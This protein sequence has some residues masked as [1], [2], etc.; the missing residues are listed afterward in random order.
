MKNIYDYLRLIKQWVGIF[1]M[2]TAKFLARAMQCV[3][4]EGDDEAYKLFTWRKSD[5]PTAKNQRDLSRASDD[6]R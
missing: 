1:F 2:W 6:A 3:G 4:V 5:E